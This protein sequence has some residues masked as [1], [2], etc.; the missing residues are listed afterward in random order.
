MSKIH[1]TTPSVRRSMLKLSG[2]S[3]LAMTMAQGSFA[4]DVT[5]DDDEVIVTGTRQVIQSSIAL[6]RQSTTIVDGLIADEIGDIPALSIGEAL[7]TLT[8]ASSHR[9]NGGATE[10]SIRGLGPFL[11][12]TTF[13]GREATNGSGDRSV[14]FS[15]FPSELMSKI[16]IYKTQDASLIEGGVAG[17]IELET[18]KPLDFGKRRIQFDLKGNINPDQLNIDNSIEGDLGYRFTGSYVD[19]WDLPNG[20]E[21]GLSIGGQISAISQ[22]EQEIR[23]SSPT[24]S[25]LWACLYNPQDP[26]NADQGWNSDASRDDDCEDDNL[27][28]GNDA[29]DTSLVGG[30]AA[31]DGEQYAWGMSSRGYRQND[32]SDTR[33]SLFGA[34]QWRPN[35]KW[36][37]NLDA[38]WSDRTQDEDRYDFYFN[39]SRRNTRNLGGFLGFDSTEDS[40]QFVEGNSGSPQQIAYQSEV[41]SGGETFTRNEQYFGIGFNADHNFNERLTASFD[42]AF[43]ETTRTEIQ[44]TLQV[45][46]GT[47]TSSTV[48]RFPLLYTIDSGI[49]QYVIGPNSNGNFD[50][51]DPM[52]FVDD[53]R[54]RVD[55]DVDRENTVF[56]SR[57]DFN[58]DTSALG[59]D[60][61]DVGVRYAELGYIN[62]GGTRDTY[63]KSDNDAGIYDCVADFSE[64]GFL[65]SVRDGALIT[66][67]DGNGATVGSFNSWAT[68]DNDCLSSYIRDGAELVYP[69]Q[70]YEASSTTDVTEESFAGYVKANFDTDMG[71]LPVRGNVG[72][73]VVHNQIDSVGFR[74]IY[75][76]VGDT[77]VGLTLV[78]DNSSVERVSDGGSYTEILP[79]FN[80]A[81]DWSE[82]VVLRAGIFRG[83]SRID[84]SDMSYSRNF[85]GIQ[86]DPGEIIDTVED[87]LNVTGSGNPFAEPLTSWNFDI[88]GEWYANE[89]TLIAVAAYYKKFTG[90]FEITEQLED[91]TVDGVTV[92]L[93]VTVQDTNDETSN[94]YGLELTATHRFSYLPGLLSGFGTKL[95][96]NIADSDFEFEDSNYGVRGVRELDGTFTQT[97]AGLIAPANVPGFSKNVLSAQLYWGWGDFDISGYYKYRSQYFQPYTSNGTRIRYVGSNEVF[98]ARASYKINDNFKIEVQGLNLFDEPRTDYFY[99]DTHFGQQSVYGPR[100]FFGV[101]G[102]F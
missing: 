27:N 96:W 15:Q 78:A 32:T 95:S 100:I 70:V 52:N 25:S 74:P 9:E 91:F 54:V 82:D 60:S 83:L 76:I 28:G 84:P 12:A 85:T 20:G 102:R 24:G 23:S 94:L 29:Y 97:T 41:T 5:A 14:N 56:A 42:V 69:D 65:S 71:A 26:D 77:T 67:V 31:D 39:N 38:Q 22:P 68:F 37:F 8:G 80:I 62:L 88:G 64:T 57:L 33:D 36:E 50:P 21:F 13:N 101:R 16:A 49:P 10:I 45:Q 86:A 46:T 4:Q 2:A 34:L 55:S 19:S 51:T 40:I 3:L 1:V 79:S 6:K 98:E 81:A 87:L 72:V 63:T 35:N 66:T 17:L 11:S 58:Y 90:G 93:P 59:F 30:V 89:D 18:L 47:S 48:G 61:V 99:E 44:Q 75:D 73:R 92:T 7:E 43:S 53:I